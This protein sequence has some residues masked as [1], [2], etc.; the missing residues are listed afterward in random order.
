MVNDQD[1]TIDNIMNVGNDTRVRDDERGIEAHTHVEYMCNRASKKIWQ[2]RRMRILDLEPEILLDFYQKE[3]RSILEFGVACWNSGVTSKL[4]E[5]IE[6]VQKICVSIILCDSEWNIPYFVGCTL[7]GIE[8][9]AYRRSDL[10]I[11]FVQK[12]CQD[13]R[14]GDLFSKNANN[15]YTRQEKP[16]YKEHPY[17]T[18]RFFKSPLCY[19]T[20]LLNLYPPSGKKNG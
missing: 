12:A 3:I 4:S 8:P 15:C 17:R 2:L 6:R 19:L 16:P 7:L 10:C 11:R 20:R 18:D 1:N 9:L 5:R 14:N 13:P